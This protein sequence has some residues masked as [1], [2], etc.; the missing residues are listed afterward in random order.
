MFGHKQLRRAVAALCAV[1]M[2]MG[3]AG[4]AFGDAEFSSQLPE[5]NATSDPVVDALFLRPLGMVSLAY[6]IA[7]FVPAAIMTAITRPTD[8]D[9]PFDQLILAPIKYVWVDEL[10]K[11]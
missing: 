9:K 7:L 11:H 3:L 1:V 2:M 6:G 4:P 10:G 5:E 8:I